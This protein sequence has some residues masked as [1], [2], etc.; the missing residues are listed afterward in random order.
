MKTHLYSNQCHDESEVWCGDLDYYRQDVPVRAMSKQVTPAPD[1][2][3]CDEC[4]LAAFQYGLQAM[5]RR[6]QLKNPE[7]H[8]KLTDTEQSIEKLLHQ[9]ATPA[10]H[11]SEGKKPT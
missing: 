10:V 1:Q 9:L 6:L 7:L 3:T 5:R 11:V 8:R 2:A 4:L